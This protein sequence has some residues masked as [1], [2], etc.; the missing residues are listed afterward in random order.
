M[1]YPGSAQA[2]SPGTTGAW[3]VGDEARDAWLRLAPGSRVVETRL[4]TTE[5][6]FEEVRL[7]E[8]ISE[9]SR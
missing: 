8:N 6:W 7:L 3:V 2:G 4:P 1:S 9:E 5:T